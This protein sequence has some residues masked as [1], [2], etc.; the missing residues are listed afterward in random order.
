MQV[1]S[2]G[3]QRELGDSLPRLGSPARAPE[4]ADIGNRAPRSAQNYYGYAL[5]G[6]LGAWRPLG[7]SRDLLRPPGDLL[8]PFSY[9]P[10]AVCVLC[11]K[12]NKHKGAAPDKSRCLLACPNLLEQPGRA[13]VLL[14]SKGTSPRNSSSS[15]RARVRMYVASDISN[16]RNLDQGNTQSGNG[17]KEKKICEGL[18]LQAVCPS[19]RLCGELLCEAAIPIASVLSCNVKCAE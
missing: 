15:S 2:L 17:S 16:F 13:A 10:C 4:E 3:M 5:E 7:T 11:I 6:P 1:A 8:A 18:P 19:A 12:E 9:T 14:S